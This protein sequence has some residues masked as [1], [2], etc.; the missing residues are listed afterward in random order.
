MMAKLDCVAVQCL[1]NCVGCFI[2]GKP[3]LYTVLDVSSIEIPYI[4]EPYAW[5]EP[6]GLH[7]V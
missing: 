3:L 5:I 4:F 6:S 2:F 1:I 7:M